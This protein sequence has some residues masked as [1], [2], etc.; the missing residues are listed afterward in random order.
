MHWCSRFFTLLIIPL[1]LASVANA[2]IV[3]INMNGSVTEIP[4]VQDAANRLGEKLYV[5]PATNTPGYKTVQLTQDL[6]RLAKLGVR[7]RAMVISGHHVKNQGYFG[8]NGEVSLHRVAS[9]LPYDDPET[10]PQV[11]SFFASLQALYL[12]GCYTGTLT[13]VDRLLLGD[14]S[15]FVNTKYVVG[16]ADKAP[17]ST[18]ADSGKTLRQMLLLESQF[19]SVSGEQIP[20][21]IKSV[22]SQYDFIIHRGQSFATQD[23]FSRVDRFLESC[24]SEE[25][26]KSILQ[27]VLLVWKYYWNEVGPIPEDPGKSPLREAYRQL[28]RNNFC[29]QMGAVQFHQVGEIPPLSTVI[30]LIH[31]KNVVKNFNR[32][33]A[34]ALSRAQKE[35]QT[36]GFENVDLITQLEQTERGLAMKKFEEMHKSLKSFFP[37]FQSDPEERTNY[38]YFNRM[39][40]DFESVLYPSEDYIPQS[41]IEPNASAMSWF[42]ILNDFSKGKDNARKKALSQLGR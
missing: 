38:L 10:L 18:N 42:M 13:N 1:A 7:P 2:D 32:L 39:L 35:L 29:L 41:W 24:Q 21:L 34:P 27:A 33:Y 12:W 4:A 11:Q 26:K 22:S 3:F 20:S 36:L 15:V 30:R 37:K 31:Y 40:N 19:R 5:L 16:F 14:N 8:S 9:L 25:S 28:Q 17:I 6:V 23:G